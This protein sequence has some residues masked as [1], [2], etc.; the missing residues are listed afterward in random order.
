[1]IDTTKIYPVNTKVR[2]LPNAW[3][4]LDNMQV[5]KS[6]ATGVYCGVHAD[7]YVRVQFQNRVGFIY[8]DPKELEIVDTGDGM[9]NDFKQGDIVLVVDDS[10]HGA[11]KPSFKKGDLLEV[12]DRYLSIV[13]IKGLC[14]FYDQDRFKKVF[15]STEVVKLFKKEYILTSVDDA[16]EYLEAH[17]NVTG[18]KYRHVRPNKAEAKG[19]GMTIA[20]RLS[21][22]KHILEVGISYCS[23]S[24]SWSN[25]IGR[26]NAL[27]ELLT[28]PQE[29]RYDTLAGCLNNIPIENVKYFNISPTSVIRQ[30]FGGN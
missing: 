8:Y 3:T 24:D 13:T 27:S 19:G 22:N 10:D 21:K 23:P 26:A 9:S 2:V 4:V 5:G 7:G 6:G 12:E 18:V 16:R 20:Y 28:N 1:M 17:K 30:M 29:F 25:T 14:P 15:P 11:G